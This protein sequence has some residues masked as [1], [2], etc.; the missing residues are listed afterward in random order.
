MSWRTARPLLERA[1]H[2]YQTTCRPD[3]PHV[4]TTLNNLALTLRELDKP[5]VA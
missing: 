3:H 1:L 4:A 5:T 2:L